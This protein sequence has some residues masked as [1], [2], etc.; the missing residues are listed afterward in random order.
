MKYLYDHKGFTLIEILIA[1]VV[2]TLLVIAFSGA[3]V[4]GLQTEGDMDDRMYVIRSINSVIEELRNE[5]INDNDNLEEK[6]K[7]LPSFQEYEEEFDEPEVRDEGGYLYSI[8]ISWAGSKY[9]VE[10]LVSTFADNGE[11][12]AVDLGWT[13]GGNNQHIKEYTSQPTQNDDNYHPGTA[14]FTENKPGWHLVGTNKE[15]HLE[16]TEGFIFETQLEVG[17]N[18]TLNIYTDGNLEFNNGVNFRGGGQGEI[19]F[20]QKTTVNYEGEESVLEGCYDESDFE[21]EF[22]S[23]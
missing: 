4:I 11:K 19:C 5:D 17:N 10:T 16:A 23:F 15:T 21:E 1:L 14:I 9:S 2:G 6:I 8:K 20:K 7:N 18:G 13:D 12:D 3:F 22:S